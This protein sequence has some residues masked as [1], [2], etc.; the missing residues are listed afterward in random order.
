MLSGGR[1]DSRYY[2]ALRT[3]DSLS[4][5]LSTAYDQPFIQRVKLWLPE[6]SNQVRGT[7]EGG[8]GPRSDRCGPRAEADDEVMG[9]LWAD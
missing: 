6:L 2:P 8:C 5:Q 3:L 7:P 9:I 1:Q 4:H